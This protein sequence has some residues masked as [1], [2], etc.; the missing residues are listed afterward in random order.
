M[1][2]GWFW[3]RY[4]HANRLAACCAQQDLNYGGAILAGWDA[5][6]ASFESGARLLDIGT[7][8][9]AVALMAAAA[10]R[11]SGKR[12]EIHGVDSAAIDPARFV[13]ENRILLADVKFHGSTR[14]ESLPFEAAG[15][16]GVTGQFALEYSDVAATLRELCRVCRRG[17]RL[18]F[19]I[20]AQ[21]GSP[22]ASARAD[23][24]ELAAV[25][26]ASGI[27]AKA[28]ECLRSAYAFEHAVVEDLHKQELAQRSREIYVEAARRLDARYATS[29]SREVIGEFLSLVRND[30]ERR[31]QL[32][33]DQVLSHLDVFETEL[34]AHMARLRAMCAAALDHS[35]VLR[36]LDLCTEAGLGEPRPGELRASDDQRLLGWTVTATR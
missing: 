18:R 20:H 17:A 3:D 31:R 11:R 27:V 12:F 22:V 8:N 14:A 9:G 1:N 15:F 5:F 32:T 33:L 30:W 23:L 28:R 16:D 21:E 6:F 2:D 35:A 13:L 7:G 4:W 29:P 36:L 19:V 10:A 24:D 25:F 26:E 34:T